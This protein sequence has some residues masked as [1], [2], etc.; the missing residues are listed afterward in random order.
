[1]RNEKFDLIW[2]ED[3]EIL[4]DE[5]INDFKKGYE[6]EYE[7]LTQTILKRIQSADEDWGLEGSIA[8]NLNY[9]R[10]SNLNPEIVEEAKGMIFSCLTKDGF[11]DPEKIRIEAESFRKDILLFN[12]SIYVN[13]NDFYNVYNLGVSYDM[14]DNRCIPRYIQGKSARN[15]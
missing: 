9:L 7:P 11:V 1:M 13:E 15:G 6:S 12:I 14:R 4:F 3:G 10:G 8:S 2:S 5:S